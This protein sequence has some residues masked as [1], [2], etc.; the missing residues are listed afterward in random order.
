MAGT[1]HI[2]DENAA[3][4]SILH[5]TSPTLC[6]KTV[7]NDSVDEVAFYGVENAL[8]CVWTTCN[9][10]IVEM[11]HRIEQADIGFTYRLPMF[12][13]ADVQG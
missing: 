2:V 10:C 12:N 5:D 9:A 7:H 1:A 4:Y 11:N 6:K 3:G 8:T 13:I